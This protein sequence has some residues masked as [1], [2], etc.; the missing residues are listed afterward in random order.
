MKQIFMILLS[1]FVLTQLACDN[2][3][4][5]YIKQ[6]YYENSDK[7]NIGSVKYDINNIKKINIDWYKGNVILENGDEIEIYKDNELKDEKKVHTLVENEVLYVKFWESKYQD[8]VDSTDKILKVKIPNGIDV[9]I[10]N[11]IGYIKID[12]LDTNFVTLN[13][14]S[15]N[16]SI[17]EIKTKTF[18]TDLNSGSIKIN[19]LLADNIDIKTISGNVKIDNLEIIKGNIKVT[20]GLISLGKIKCDEFDLEAVSGNIIINDINSKKLDVDNVSGKIEIGIDEVEKCSINGTSSNVDIF[21]LNQKGCSLEYKTTSGKLKTELEY[22]VKDN[23]NI[24]FD[25]CS[26]MYINTTSGIIKIMKVE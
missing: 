15:G 3:S 17:N 23:K 2:V 5:R 1:I 4:Y 20:S 13:T 8:Y 19:K 9:Y 6:D 16:I 22:I 12:N 18:I 10:N 11:R 7:Y 25:G 24:F 14:N 26:N 21:L